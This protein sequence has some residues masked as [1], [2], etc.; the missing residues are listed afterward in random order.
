MNI[1]RGLKLRVLGRK[2]WR[3]GGNREGVGKW[4]PRFGERE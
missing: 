4:D 3:D 2:S 1:V